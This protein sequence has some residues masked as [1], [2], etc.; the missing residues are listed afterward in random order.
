[1]LELANHVSSISSLRISV[2]LRR[3]PGGPR[4]SVGSRWGEQ[5]SL[6]QSW[7][8]GFASDLGGCSLP[9]P[10][11]V[12]VAE[13]G[14]RPAGWGDSRGPCTA[15]SLPPT[16][17]QTG[18]QPHHR[19]GVWI[20]GGQRWGEDCEATDLGHCWPG[21]V[22]VGGLGSLG[23]ERGGQGVRSPSG[24]KYGHRGAERAGQADG[25]RQDPLSQG[26]GIP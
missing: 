8:C 13:T 18:L 11:E 26:A 16:P 23:R 6:V 7:G 22:S 15:S 3:D 1:M 2:S 17:S 20:Q 25:E 10:S 5:V 14:R 9:A 19:R 4:G 21:A 24:L 12:W